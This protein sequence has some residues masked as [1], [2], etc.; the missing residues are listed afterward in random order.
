MF[1]ENQDP[2]V[3]YICKKYEVS[4]YNR[5]H[6]CNKF[7]SLSF[8]RHQ[9]NEQ[10][11]SDKKKIEKNGLASLLLMKELTHHLLVEGCV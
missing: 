7:F 11:T 10:Q 3:C 5:R 4:I 6:K 8:L 1:E 9:S 2:H